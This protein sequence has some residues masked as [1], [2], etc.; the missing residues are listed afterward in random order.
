MAVVLTGS[1]NG[2]KKVFEYR[3]DAAKESKEH[4][5]V[6]RLWAIRKVGYL[7]D[8]IRLH[9]E[10]PELK[11]EIVALGKKYGIVTPYTSYLVVEDHPIAANRA[12]PMDERP[13]RAESNENA[14]FFGNALGGG[15]RRDLGGL[16]GSGASPPPASKP[17]AAPEA[18]ALLKKGE[19][20]VGVAV[21]KSVRGM[22]EA[23]KDSSSSSTA[24]RSA[25]GRTYVAK[26]GAWVDTELID[27]MGKALK[28]KYLS[29][30]YFAL[31]KAKPELKAAF[32]LGD[33]VVLLVAPGKSV[34]IAPDA[35]ETD[36][37]KALSALG[38]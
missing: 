13:M 35:G 6:P 20:S 7:L 36:T 4:D 2:K 28:V 5:F 3:A 31:L 15:R 11:D 34:S 32:A 9:G 12:R 22:K 26:G 33:R 27:T 1:V 37:K 23:D 38:L 21:A 14:D 18:E 10:K 29:D 30:A 24:A 19:G 17:M 25:G 16:G 8:E